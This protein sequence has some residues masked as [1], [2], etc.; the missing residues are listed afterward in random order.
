MKRP[1]LI[2]DLLATVAPYPASMI[3]IAPTITGR[4]FFPGGRGLYD[5]MAQESPPSRPVM[6]V[7]QDFDTHDGFLASVA[8]GHEADS[9][10]W[11]GI[12][13]ILREHAIDPRACFFT[14]VLMGARHAQS[15]SG[16]SPA[17]RDAQFVDRCLAFFQKQVEFMKPVAVVA[18]GTVPAALLSRVLARKPLSPDTTWVDIDAAGFSLVEQASIV[19]IDAPP[20]HFASSVHPCLWRS[21]VRHRRVRGVHGMEAHRL[22]WTAVARAA[23]HAQG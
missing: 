21:N 18:L 15:N 20:F 7:G 14:N 3:E 11:R 22:I 16:P 8:Q 6:L 23:E 17:L 10:T 4:A 2:A 13:A 5:G 1:E 12:D 9:P 19:G